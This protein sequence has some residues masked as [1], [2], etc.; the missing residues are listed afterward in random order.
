MKLLDSIYLKAE[1]LKIPLHV[2]L[3]LTQRCNENCIHCYIKGA[4]DKFTLSSDEKELTFEQIVKLLDEL[5]Q[6]G[7]LNLTFTGGEALLREDFFAIAQAAKERNFAV[8][9]FS[10]AQLINEDCAD[11]LAKIMPVCIYF[12]IYGTEA[13]THDRITQLPGSFERLLNAIQLLKERQI[14]VGL[15]TI[16]MK[17]NIGQ[18]K[19]VFILGKLLGVETHEFGEEI[20]AKIDGFCQPKSFQIDELSLYSYY[21]GDIPTSPDYV[22]ELPLDK[23]LKRPVCGAGVFGVCISCYGDVY[24]CVE[25]R[26]PLGNIKFKSFKEIWHNEE[27]FLGELRSVREYGDLV[28][29][30]SCSLVNFCRR[31]PGRA[32]LDTG[33]WRNCHKNAYQRAALTKEINKELIGKEGE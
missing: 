6:E 18:L 7:T 30:R 20:T 29:C 27:G 23:A 5:V 17:N 26:M 8:S 21:K 28:V 10:N 2:L 19:E 4:K 25:W 14:K 1:A 15:K 12:S 13:F 32:F 16:V 24:P 11:K 22:E 31:C 33:E 3:E 9:I